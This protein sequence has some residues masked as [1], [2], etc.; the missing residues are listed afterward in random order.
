MPKTGR[1]AFSL[2]L[3]HG[4]GSAKSIHSS[5][6]KQI[7][8][9]KNGCFCEWRLYQHIVLSILLRRVVDGGYILGCVINGRG[10]VDLNIS[11]LL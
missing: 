7:A 9:A 6:A 5:G 10:G 8:K 2:S 3:C 11:H 1:P 4:Y